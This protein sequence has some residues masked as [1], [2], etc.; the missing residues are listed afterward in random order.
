MP[1]HD[2]F[3]R[4]ARQNPNAMALCAWDGEVTY[5]ELDDLSTR[6][7][8]YLRAELKVGSG[9]MVLLCFEK[10]MWT[11]VSMLAVIKAGGSFVPMDTEQ[12]EDRLL[13]MIEQTGA[14]IVLCSSLKLRLASR[15]AKLTVVIDDAS[16]KSMKRKDEEI[17]NTV[18]PS[19]TMYVVFTSGSTGTP[20]GVII[21][22]ANLSSAVTHQAIELGFRADSRVLDFSSYSFDACVFN[23]FYTLL[24]GGCLCVPSDASRKD[25]LTGSINSMAIN[26]VQLT[27]SVARLLDPRKVPSL[28][29]L[30]L[31]GRCSL[32]LTSTHGSISN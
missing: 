14:K 11:S 17:S 18:D 21:T 7:A 9:V 29:V 26:L 30:V 27:P 20:K 32:S 6:L 24:L 19:T 28:Q 31:T 12:P 10:S 22:H 25:D 13:S 8:Q 5:I 1:A 16:V 23:L 2:L 4:R 15:L 3:S